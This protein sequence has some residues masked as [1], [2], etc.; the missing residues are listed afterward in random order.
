[1][2]ILLDCALADGPYQQFLV[3]KL[4]SEAI[5]TIDVILISN[6]ETML[7]L[8]FISEFGGFKGSGVL[9]MLDPC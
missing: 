9:S 5:R 8:P 3:P 2:R 4:D 1:M 6:L 7:A